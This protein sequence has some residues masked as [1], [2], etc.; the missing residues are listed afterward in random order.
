LHNA[1]IERARRYEAARM[2]RLVRR[3]EVLRDRR[4]N[5][6]GHLSA[7]A[8]N[9]EKCFFGAAGAVDAS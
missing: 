2:K 6:D 5:P 9:A 4:R 1:A 7:E 8:V 3:A